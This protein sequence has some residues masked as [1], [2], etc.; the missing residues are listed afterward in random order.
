[1]ANSQNLKLD[2]NKS[3]NEFIPGF[4]NIKSRLKQQQFLYKLVMQTY[5]D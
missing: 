5:Q 1:L 2:G 3:K 4:A